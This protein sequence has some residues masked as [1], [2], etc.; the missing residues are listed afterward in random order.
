MPP[1]VHV[2]EVESPTQSQ[3]HDQPISKS[4]YFRHTVHSF[5][6]L[7]GLVSYFKKGVFDN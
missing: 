5:A 7:A 4:R 3:G 2:E 1:T 6:S